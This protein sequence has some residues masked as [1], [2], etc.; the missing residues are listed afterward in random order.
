MAESGGVSLE[1]V[2]EFAQMSGHPVV[3]RAGDPN[4]ERSDKDVALG[5]APAHQREIAHEG[6]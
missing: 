5:I 2:P 1:L 3:A 6:G 4:D